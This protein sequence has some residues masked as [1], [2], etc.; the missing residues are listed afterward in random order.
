MVRRFCS[1]LSFFCCSI[2]FLFAALLSSAAVQAQYVTS[3]PPQS[4]GSWYNPAQDGHGFNV[5][6]LNETTILVYWYT[7]RPD[8]TSTFLVGTATTDGFSDTYSGDFFQTNGMIFGDF[9]PN[10]RELIP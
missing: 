10:D 2:T 4:A 9:N 8:G 7:Y 5:E 1:R 6:I 3:L